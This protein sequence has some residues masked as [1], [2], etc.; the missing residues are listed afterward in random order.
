MKT[1]LPQKW[2]YS[3]L[4]DIALI[5]MGQSPPSVYYNTEKEGIPFFQGKAEF[6]E[7]YPVPVKWCT[8]PGKI[9][10]REDLLISVRAPVGPTNLAP[11]ECC[12]GRGLAAIRP[13]GEIS[14]R[15]L[16]YFFRSI[17]SYLD[18]LGTG[19]T[20]KAILGK[21]LNGIVV[22]IA[23]I[24]QQK[25]IVEEIEKQFSRLD[26]AVENLQRVKANLKRYKA[27]VLKAAVEG[28]LTEEW[29]KQ[30]P[31][32]EPASKLL[33]RILT[34]RR[35]K[36]E[37]TELAKMKAKGK[38][39][40]DD[41]WKKK[42]KEPGKPEVDSC[43]QLPKGWIWATVEQLA[44]DQPRSIQSGPF[45]SNLK[46]SEFQKEGKLVIGIDNVQDGHFSIGSENLPDP[47]IIAAEIV[48]DLEAALEQF[49]EIAEDL[50]QG[51]A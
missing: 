29:R 45:G 13:I 9:A 28:K 17:E 44:S 31:D 50:E 51:P 5:I 7:L 3:N 48:E 23:P 18:S 36:W 1:D 42:Y 26:E 25:R 38:V 35:T 39:P 11:S 37:E 8:E 40:K 16:F 32:V 15:Y 21:I 19:T 43:P 34:E 6:G 2:Q 24:Q 4:D 27:A 33:E 20:F 49:S 14:S 22:P 30:N 47:E 46:H 41:K 10:Q 12:I